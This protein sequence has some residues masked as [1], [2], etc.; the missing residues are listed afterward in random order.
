MECKLSDDDFRI[1]LEQFNR[2]WSGYKKVRKGVKK[3]L[4]R[5]MRLVKITCFSEYLK[6]ISKDKGVRMD[7]EECLQVTISR[8]FRDRHL[9]SYLNKTLLPE[10]IE[11]HPGGIRVWAAGCGCGEEVYSL[12]ILWNQLNSP[13]HLDIV[14]TDINY[15]NLARAQEGC[16]QLSSMKEV[17][18]LMRIEC[19]ER[20][21]DRDNYCI[22]DRY[23]A[24]IIW[25]QHNFF[26][27]LN[28]EKFQIIFLRNSLLTYHEGEQRNHALRQ[29]L[30]VIDLGGYLV[31]GSHEKIP[32]QF[33]KLQRVPD[34]PSLYRVI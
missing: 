16:Y 18:E 27:P 23:R 29:I 13:V 31:A 24:N 11:K 15:Q 33:R 34:C 9:W 1:L 12:A 4:R 28:C 7:C 26:S 22:K 2:P 17:P 25:K 32:E 19:F 30:R 5:H 8:F 6:L 20:Q 3:R 21:N 10:L 14:A